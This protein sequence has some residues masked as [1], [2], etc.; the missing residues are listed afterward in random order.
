MKPLVDEETYKRLEA[1]A[2]AFKKGAGFRFQCYLWLKWLLS[3]NY[4]SD[5]W[6]QFAY[7]KSRSPIICGSN[8]YGLEP[9][10][11]LWTTIPAAR[12]ANMLTGMLAFRD[13][14]LRN[15][16]TPVLVQSA[17]P[18][19]NYQYTRQFNTTRIPGEAIDKIVHIKETSHVAVYSDGKW[20]K[21]DLT[22]QGHRLNPKELEM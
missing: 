8:I 7:C 9:V 11:T 17:I 6:E 20:Y 22:H 18:L 10:D 16:T 14:T 21:L 2:T 1:D 4:V 5:W 13:A 3:S 12:C 19:C 15:E